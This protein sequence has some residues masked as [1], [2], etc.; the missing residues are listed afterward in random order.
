MKLNGLLELG[1]NLPALHTLAEMLAAN[2]R[3]SAPL[4]IYHAARPYVVATIACAVNRPL[5]LLTARSNRARQ[6]VDELRTWLPDEIPVHNFADPDALSYERIP[7]ASETRQR[8]L[9]GLVGLLTN[10]ERRTTDDDGRQSPIS[11]LQS[12]ISNLQ[13][14]ISN[15]QSPISNLQS[16]IV[17]ASARALMAATLPVR[18]MRLALRPI[19]QGQ[20]FDLNKMLAAWVGLGYE[21]A[22]VV[23]A[24]GQFSRRGGIVDV[25][26]PNLRKPLRI[27]LFGDEVDSLRSFDP[28]TQR[29]IARVEQAWIG[30]ASEALPRLG[31]RAAERLQALDLS[32]CH[33]PARIEYEREIEGLLAG[34]GFRNLEWWL[35]YLYSQP[36]TLLDYL[37]PQGIV[38]ADD[39]AEL[40]AAFADLEGQ[41]QQL[42]RDLAAAGDLPARL[43][44][45]YFTAA[46]LGERL[47]RSQ[48]IILGNGWLGGQTSEG[49]GTGGL[50]IRESGSDHTVAPTHY[51]T[52]ALSDSFF[53]G[54]RY[55]GQVR[56]AV[57]ELQHNLIGGDRIVMVT[58]Q[59]PRLAEMLEQAG[60]AI[61]P[62]ENAITLPPPG[63]TLIQ[64]VMDEGWRLETGNWKLEAGNSKVEAG[65][66]KLEAGTQQPASSNQQPASSNQQPASSNQ[67]LAT[68][69]QLPVSRFWFLTDAELFGW[70][71]PKPRR[72]QRTRAMSPEVFFADVKPGDYVVHIEHGI[73]QF[74]GLVKLMLDGM[75]REYLQVEYAQRDQ[76]YVP[77]HQA[78]R[79]ARY[80]GPGEG[81]PGLHRLGTLEWEQ[82]KAR[83]KKA[84]AEIADELLELYAARE[85]VQGHAFSPDATWQA[86]LEA[87]FPYVETEDQLVAIEAVK[88]DMEQPRPMDRLICGD[89]GYGKTEV[90]LRAAFKAIMDGKQVAVLVPTTVLAQ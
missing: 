23:D 45:P 44:P 57:T 17:I 20:E 36:A 56:T 86:E 38:L 8:R 37:P 62:S 43:T 63:L 31:V 83:A 41:A 7:W 82:V 51:R 12:P 30:P 40:S 16:P 27:E 4:A 21:S 66:W 72:P 68:S 13:S 54:P 71:K 61:A 35:P 73:G 77:V 89:V 14:P 67:L 9:E 42:A 88:H 81:T 5:V 3:P 78:D 33:P 46:V 80:I 34:S 90:A 24:P 11:N 47:A 18:E 64:G 60:H 39:A 70:G 10:D 2:E 87:S 84:V 15:L 28:S 29:T 26:P 50:E 65:S 19:R 22:A 25:W 76:L 6:W 58:R 49:P 48:P 52:S 59:A 53:A 85:V 79:L 75:E 1:Q 74:K 69:N 55:G 32:P